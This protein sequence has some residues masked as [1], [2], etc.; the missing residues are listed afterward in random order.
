MFKCLNLSNQL[1]MYLASS[2]AV[3]LA[4]LLGLSG[5]SL[6]KA[7]H[8]L[9]DARADVVSLNTQLIKTEAQ[10]DAANDSVQALGD[11]GK[12][13]LDSLIAELAVVSKQ[14]SGVPAKI[15]KLLKFKP[16]GQTKCERWEEAD[17]AVLG[18]LK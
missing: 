12:G 14:T 1:G 13:K 9:K 3:V 18:G 8:D 5:L 7:R 10:R 17:R 4:V 2:A 16:A 15:D 11:L 6:V